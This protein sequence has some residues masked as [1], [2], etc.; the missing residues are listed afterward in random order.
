MAFSV[1]KCNLK[2]GTLES[3]ILAFQT[4]WICQKKPKCGIMG[5]VF[6]D[7]FCRIF[8]NV[9]GIQNYLPRC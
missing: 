4:G 6:W 7:I 5:L 3:W 1:E 2:G 9:K 8:E